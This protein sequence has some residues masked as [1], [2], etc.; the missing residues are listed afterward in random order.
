VRN[1]LVKVFA[2]DKPIE[3]VEKMEALFISNLAVDILGVYVVVA[4]N[5]LGVFMFLA[6]L[7]NS[8]LFATTLAKRS[9]PLQIA[10]RLTKTFPADDGR[11]VKLRFAANS[12]NNTALQVDRPAL[13][14]P[15]AKG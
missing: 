6:K 7:L 13:V 15:T 4:D 3:I 5:E 11:K 9:M 2:T 10:R 8:I 1:K 12:S 14:Q